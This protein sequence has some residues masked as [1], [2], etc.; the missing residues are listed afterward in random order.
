MFSG[1]L[2]TACHFYQEYTY[3]PITTDKMKEVL[4]A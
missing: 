4:E 2:A 3:K 1:A